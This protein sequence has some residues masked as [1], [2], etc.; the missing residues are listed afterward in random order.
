MATNHRGAAHNLFRR[1]N[2]AHSVERSCA[3]SSGTAGNAVQHAGTC[4]DLLGTG[5][6]LANASPC[7]SSNIAYKSS[8]LLANNRM[9]SAQD[10]NSI[11]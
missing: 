1:C 8:G 2:A 11:M 3:T 7:N 10:R 9:S 6:A 4:R 5:P